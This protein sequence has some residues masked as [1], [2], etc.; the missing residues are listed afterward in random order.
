MTDPNATEPK[1][2]AAVLTAYGPAP[3][4]P[5]PQVID[6]KSLAEALAWRGRRSDPTGLYWLGARYY[7][8]E[9]G[10]F[11]SP[12]PLGHEATLD[13]YSFADGDP[14]NYF[15]PDGRCARKALGDA[16][17]YFVGIGSYHAADEG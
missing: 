12:D 11:I 1:W 13:L 17:R 8:P 7:D 6:A 4:E 3:G 15:D 5:L 9:H 2:H 10:R 16:G 14:V